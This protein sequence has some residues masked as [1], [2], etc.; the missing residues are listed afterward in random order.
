MDPQGLHFLDDLKINGHAA[1]GAADDVAGFGRPGM[2]FRANGF[3]FT[4]VQPDA[5]TSG[6]AINDDAGAETEE[7]ALQFGIGTAGA[8][9]GLPGVWFVGRVRHDFRK[10]RFAG[11]HGAVHL[12]EFL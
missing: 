4:V 11:G 9:A 12:L 5:M 10:W 2:G 6:A 8:F 3:E 7:F 1:T